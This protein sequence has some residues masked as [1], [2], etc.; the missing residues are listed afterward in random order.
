MILQK[1]VDLVLA[2]LRKQVEML[3]GRREILCE[4][5]G[6]EGGATAVVSVSVRFVEL[7]EAETATWDEQ[8]L[9]SGSELRIGCHVTDGPHDY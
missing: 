9:E 1:R 2:G 7:D 5:G 3:G 4:V 8:Y 6:E